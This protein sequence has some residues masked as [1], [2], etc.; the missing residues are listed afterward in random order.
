MANRRHGFDRDPASA[1]PSQRRTFATVNV[2]RKDARVDREA[3][4]SARAGPFAEG[5]RND[6]R[7]ER[8]RR[9]VDA[10]APGHPDGGGFERQGRRFLQRET[11]LRVRV[12]V[13]RGRDRVDRSR[14][15]RLDD[16]LVPARRPISI[17]QERAPVD[18]GGFEVHG[19]VRGIA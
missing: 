5:H 17:V 2:A 4:R 13:D 19:R 3:H 12:S 6:A 1:Q 18:H 8:F 14:V 10:I 9:D 15:V 16:R 11:G 7:A